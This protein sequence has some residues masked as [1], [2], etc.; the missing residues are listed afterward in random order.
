MDYG[1]IREDGSI[2]IQGNP[3]SVTVAN[4]TA[5]QRKTLA[6]LRGELPMTYTEQPEYNPETQYVTDYWVEEN[7]KAVQHW[8]VHDIEMNES[9]E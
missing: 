7:N 3:V 4:P 5:D 2:Q 9:E 6:K 8:T 1:K